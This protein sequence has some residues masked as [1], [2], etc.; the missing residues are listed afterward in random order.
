MHHFENETPKY[1]KKKSTGSK[2]EKRSDHKHDYEII[3]LENGLIGSVW[4][5]RC[6]VCGRLKSKSY[7][8]S[9]EGLK[10]P[11]MR[12]WSNMSYYS[13]EELHKQYPNVKIYRRMRNEK[14]YILWNDTDIEQI[15]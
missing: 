10:K 1:R 8:A 3:L 5:D 13:I 7:A 4:M 9:I 14:G 15:Y 2:S 6:R 12:E 11:D